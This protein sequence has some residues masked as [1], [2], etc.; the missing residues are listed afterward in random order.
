MIVLLKQFIHRLKYKNYCRFGKNTNLDS[1]CHF[2]GANFIS[3]NSSF[4]NSTLG[5]ASYIGEN[6]FVKNTIVGR[7][8]SIAG[9]V[10]TVTGDHPVDFISSHPVFYDTHNESGISYV[11]QNQYSDFHTNIHKQRNNTAR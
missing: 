7:Y 4:L 3:N 11:S 10:K 1:S 9:G 2:E 5:Y 8:S 6:S